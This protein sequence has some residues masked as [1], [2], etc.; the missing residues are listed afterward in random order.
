MVQILPLLNVND[1]LFTL[2]LINSVLYT[3]VTQFR[4]NIQFVQI[5]NFLT[6]LLDI[7]IKLIEY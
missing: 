3:V 2:S 7:S 4:L 5:V 6:L 1:K